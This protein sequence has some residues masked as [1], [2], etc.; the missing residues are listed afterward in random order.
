MKTRIALLLL[1]AM[2]AFSPP[3]GHAATDNELIRGGCGG[4]LWLDAAGVTAFY[5]VNC[6]VRGWRAH[7]IGHLAI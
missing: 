7:A 1:A 5:A 3:L 4:D 2:V 6:R